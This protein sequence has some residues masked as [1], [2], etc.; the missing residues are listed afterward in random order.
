MLQNEFHFF[1]A[2]AVFVASIVPLYLTFKLKNPKLK[3]LTLVLGI[4]IIIHGIY[5]SVGSL[6]NIFLA[7]GI[8]DPLSAMVLLG[9]GLMYLRF[10][11]KKET[12]T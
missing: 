1:N 11:T 2:I 10:Q 8:L 6:G 3:K 9:F 4:F 12:R 7:K 5:H